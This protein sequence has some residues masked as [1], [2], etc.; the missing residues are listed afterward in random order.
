M[1]RRRVCTIMTFVRDPAAAAGFWSE[2]LQAPAHPELAMVDVGDVRLFFHPADDER[3]PAGGTVAYFGA[4][5]FDAFRDA[6][7]VAGCAM[8]RGPLSLSDGRRIC[9]LRDPFGAIWGIEETAPTER[10]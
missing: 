4:D 5:D 9:Q 7:L 10:G 3:N 1:G 8:H 2:L 6:L